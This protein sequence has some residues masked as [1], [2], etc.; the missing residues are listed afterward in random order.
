MA[1]EPST[2]GALKITARFV[3]KPNFRAIR[4]IG[5]SFPARSFPIEDRTKAP[6][7]RAL[8]IS[9]TGLWSSAKLVLNITLAP[10]LSPIKALN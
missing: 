6:V 1:D 5:L 7:L 4:P 8:S 2:Q 10:A 9:M 3:Q